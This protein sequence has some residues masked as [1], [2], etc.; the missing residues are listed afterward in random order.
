MKPTE[1]TQPFARYPTVVPVRLEDL[2]PTD[3]VQNRAA[4]AYGLN[5]TAILPENGR[6]SNPHREIV[7]KEK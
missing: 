7:M 3:S 5:Q 6:L 1:K 4:E 2:V